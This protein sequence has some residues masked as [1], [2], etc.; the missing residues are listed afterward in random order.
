MKGAAPSVPSKVRREEERVFMA[1]KV[2]PA[3]GGDQRFFIAEGC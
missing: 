3:G 2:P 1:N